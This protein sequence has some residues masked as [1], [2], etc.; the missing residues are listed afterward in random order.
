MGNTSF[1]ASGARPSLTQSVIA[2]SILMAQSRHLKPP[3]F[4]PAPHRAGIL[5]KTAPSIHFEPDLSKAISGGYGD[6]QKPMFVRK[7]AWPCSCQWLAMIAEAGN[8]GMCIPPLTLSV[9]PVM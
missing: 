7:P 6:S 1:L 4:P 5:V 2:S 9:S 3:E 8:Q